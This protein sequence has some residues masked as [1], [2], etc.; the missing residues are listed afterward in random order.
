MKNKF[1]D[2][3]L[4][5]HLPNDLIVSILFKLPLK[6]LKRFGGLYKS[7]ALLFEN[8]HFIDLFRN[9]VISSHHSYYDDTSLVLCLYQ[10]YNDP[11]KYESCLYLLNGEKFQNTEKLNW[12]NP[13]EDHPFEKY[14]FSYS[15]V[16]GILCFYLNYYNQSMY[17]WNPATGELKI[18][19]RSPTEYV[20]PHVKAYI[21][22]DGFGYDC[23]RDDYKV[24]RTVTFDEN[25]FGE[26][27]EELFTIEWDFTPICEIYSQKSNCWRKVDMDY[28]FCSKGGE[29]NLYLDGMCHWLNNWYS[30]Q[31]L[32]FQLDI[33]ST[34]D[35]V[36]LVSF[37]M[38]NETYCATVVPIDMA[39]DDDF[40]IYGVDR[41]LFV[42]NGSIAMMSNDQGKTTFYISIL[43]EVGKKETWKKLF[44]FDPLPGIGTPIG[45][46]SMGNILFKTKD[47]QLVWFDLS[48]HKITKVGIKVHPGIMFHMVIYRESL[49]QI[50]GMKS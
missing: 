48:T 40:V 19:P 10:Y 29:N 23:V 44:I 37:D 27:D 18:L 20:P 28:A 13:L 38:S 36:Y 42:L 30:S 15:S 45:A 31:D 32:E 17:L 39:I 3:K 47:G 26:R 6:S 24:I 8:S 41:F 2:E 35:Q 7:W 12:K 46:R 5:N 49:V 43:G 22:N 21:T 34:D 4:G 11:I 9:N 50:Q 25:S 33:S 14:I 16:N 1:V